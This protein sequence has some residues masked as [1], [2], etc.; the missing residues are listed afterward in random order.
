M[1]QEELEDKLNKAIK[2]NICKL[3]NYDSIGKN[4]S[5]YMNNLH[6]LINISD[7]LCYLDVSYYDDISALILKAGACCS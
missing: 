5:K 1:T 6:M 7:C 2:C 3:T 4:Y